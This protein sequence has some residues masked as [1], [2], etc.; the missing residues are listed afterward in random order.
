MAEVVEAKKEPGRGV[1]FTVLVEQGTMKVG[2]NFLAGFT[3]GKVRA[4]LDERGNALEQVK[5]GEPC[6]ILGAKDVPEAGDRF[7]VVEN[8]RQARELA[9]K[10]RRLQRQQQIVG[11]KQVIDLDNLAALMT[12][13]WPPTVMAA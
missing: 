7:Y 11:P 12:M 6:E 4:L 1:L 3:D 9:D 5:P 8:E 2:N 10:R 13:L